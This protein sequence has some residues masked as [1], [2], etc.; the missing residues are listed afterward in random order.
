MTKGNIP[1]RLKNRWNPNG[2]R[3]KYLSTNT[4]KKY[5]LRKLRAK[6]MGKWEK[7]IKELGMKL[8]RIFQSRH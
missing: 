7:N 2:I 6:E 8:G 3:K 1:T 4:Q 5:K